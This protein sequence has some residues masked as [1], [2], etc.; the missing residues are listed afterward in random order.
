MPAVSACEEVEIVGAWYE[1]REEVLR[2]KTG[3]QIVWLDGFGAAHAGDLRKPWRVPESVRLD[4]GLVS[5]I[6][7]APL[8]IPSTPK[9][10]RLS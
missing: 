6:V 4:V 9:R 3:L 7:G 10:D 5:K 8:E 2:G 1:S